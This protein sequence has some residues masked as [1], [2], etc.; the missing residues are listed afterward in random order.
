MSE[1]LTPYQGQA[2]VPD[3]VL[4]MIERV[5]TNPDADIE[6]LER[7]L[8]M[9]ERIL[10]RQHE[11]AFNE[12][13]NRVQAA[14]GRI[15]TDSDNPHTKSRYASYAA[16]DRVMRPIYT[17]EGLSISFTTGDA[18]TEVV[19][20]IGHLSGHGHTRK[21]QVDMPADGKGAKGG[22]VMTKTHAAGAAMQYGMRY[23]LK[24]MFNLA[25]GED[26]DGNG[27]SGETKYIS[28]DEALTIHAKLTDNEIPMGPFLDWLKRTMKCESIETI[29]VKALDTVMSTIDA[30]IKAKR[31]VA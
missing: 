29:S 9:Q 27:A 31:R 21:Y 26:T 4:A 13:M 17:K 16:L 18:P 15:A 19:R 7:L 30:K 28:E 5:A 10:D 20:V 23:L 25:I 6:K 24:L 2:L 14:T 3:P 8:A 1:D 11:D 12:A 22:D